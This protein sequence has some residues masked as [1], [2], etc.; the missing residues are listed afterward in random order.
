NKGMLLTAFMQVSN[1][2]LS[3]EPSNG[4]HVA[5]VDVAGSV[6]NDKGGVGGTFNNRIA[7]T[8]PSTDV[9][10]ETPDPGYGYA[11]YLGPG[12]Y[13]VRV[14]AID[15]KTGRSGSA[16]AWIEIPD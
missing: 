7:V 5:V 6:H 14:G 9:A 15:E 2:F 4:K 12:L 1:E 13:Q 3:Y 11:V 16:H 10:N 8:A